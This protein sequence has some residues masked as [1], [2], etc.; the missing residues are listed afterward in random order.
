[1]TVTL[2]EQ[3]RW[4]V[5]TFMGVTIVIGASWTGTENRQERSSVPQGLSNPLLSIGC[6]YFLTQAI[7][8]SETVEKRF[9]LGRYP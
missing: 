4:D 2:P 3:R 5:G 6:E 7:R 9:S 8:A 1:M